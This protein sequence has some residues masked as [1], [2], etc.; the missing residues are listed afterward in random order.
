MRTYEEFKELLIKRV[1]AL[2]DASVEKMYRPNRAKSSTTLVIKTDTNICL[3]YY[4]ENLYKEYAEHCSCISMEDAIDKVVK[5]IRNRLQEISEQIQNN[6]N[7]SDFLEKLRNFDEV[8]DLVFPVLLN[9]KNNATCIEKNKRVYVP[10]TFNPDLI[11]CF[12]VTMGNLPK[13]ESDMLCTAIIDESLLKLWNVSAETLYQVALRN[14][15]K[16]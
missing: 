6:D 5:S 10:C 2:F 9:R 12:Y 14:F 13:D 7:G 3:N 1:T 16:M 4:T 11:S 15:S 8:K